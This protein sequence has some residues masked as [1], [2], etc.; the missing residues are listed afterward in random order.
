MDISACGR[1]NTTKV[2][3]RGARA[4][5]MN[6]PHYITPNDAEQVLMPNGVYRRTMATTDHMMLIEA[7]LL[8]DTVVPEHSHMQEQIGY[9]ARG[10][11]EFTIGGETRICNP[12]DSYAIPGDVPHSARALIDTILVEVFSPP[13]EDYRNPTL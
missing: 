4:L 8:R 6:D 5:I 3:F 2:H 10:Q 12:G 7:L 13:R 9:V 1:H 11:I